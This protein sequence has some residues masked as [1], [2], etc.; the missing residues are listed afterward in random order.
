MCV[1]TER[2]KRGKITYQLGDKLVYSSIYV[3]S[4]SQQ[5]SESSRL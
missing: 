3:F 1:V 5:K 4:Q 2:T